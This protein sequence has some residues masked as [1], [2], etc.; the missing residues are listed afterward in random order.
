MLLILLLDYLLSN[1]TKL[2]VFGVLV[3][4]LEAFSGHSFHAE[5]LAIYFFSKSAVVES[6]VLSAHN[7]NDSF[8]SEF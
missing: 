5:R 1:L 6:A 7:F 8:I 2:L 3:L 4:V